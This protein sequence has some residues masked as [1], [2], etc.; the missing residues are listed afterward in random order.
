MPCTDVALAAIVAA[1]WQSAYL[2]QRTFGTTEFVFLDENKSE[3]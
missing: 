1:L 3:L 2:L